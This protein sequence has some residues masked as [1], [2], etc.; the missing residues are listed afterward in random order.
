MVW[1]PKVLKHLLEQTLLFEVE[2][3]SSSFASLPGSTGA[4]EDEYELDIQGE[5]AADTVE[6]GFLDA[7][8]SI[9]IGG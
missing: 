3:P 4:I 1:D 9:L 5:K 8:E 7:L 2:P 6:H